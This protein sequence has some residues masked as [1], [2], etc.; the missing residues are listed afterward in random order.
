MRPSRV[1]GRVTSWFDSSQVEGASTGACAASVESIA[2][3]VLGEPLDVGEPDLADQH[4]RPRVRVGDG[5]P[6]AVDVVQ[7]IPVGVGVLAGRR[8]L[9][10]LRQLGVLDQ[11]G[12]GVDPHSADAAIEPEAQDL[13]VLA[14][15][16]WMVPVEIRLLGGE[17]VEVPLP[18][19]PVGVDRAGPGVAREVGDP[20]VRHLGSVVAPPRSE[21]E[22]LALRG[23][24]PGG[25]RRL[26]PAVAVGDVIGDDV[27]DGADAE[28]QSFGDEG[29][30]LLEGSEG[31]VDRAVVGDVVAAVGE[32]GQVPGREPD[33]VDAQVFEVSQVPAHA[34]QV[35]D[36]I[37]VRV[38]EA[39]RVD[40]VDDR[41]APP[42]GVDGGRGRTRGRR[43]SEQGQVHAE[44][45]CA[46]RTAAGVGAG[47][48]CDQNVCDGSRTVAR[49][50]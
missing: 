30:C 21:P 40:L 39:P 25:Q 22:A 45:F 1:T 12:R 5:P 27:D 3:Q 4:A 46:G 11:Q 47:W 24:G 2:A 17:Q 16:V 37:A 50:R 33:G 42:E 14:E 28:L 10:H 18:R 35:A 34:G 41:T 7:L 29:L 26:E 20:V 23:T 6:V 48:S 43:L 32:R 9:G 8:V 38:G 15:D 49:F 31:G 36:T 44:P 13:L 19:C